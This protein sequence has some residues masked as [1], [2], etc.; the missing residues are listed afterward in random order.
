MRVQVKTSRRPSGEMLPLLVLCVC[1][2]GLRFASEL[3]TVAALRALL[4]QDTKCVS[5]DCFIQIYCFNIDAIFNMAV[6][7]EQDMLLL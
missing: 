2:I 5:T 4:P 6:K 7:S 1:C 3:S